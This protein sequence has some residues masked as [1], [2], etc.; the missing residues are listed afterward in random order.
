MGN[1]GSLGKLN[2]KGQVAP[3]GVPQTAANGPVLRGPGGPPGHAAAPVIG[4]RYPT[5]FYTTLLASF[6]MS[7]LLFFI[8]TPFLLS[9]YSMF[10]LETNNLDVTLASFE[11]SDHSTVQNRDV[12]M[13]AVKDWK[14]ALDAYDFQ[15][16][17]EQFGQS[18]DLGALTDDFDIKEPPIGSIP[19]KRLYIQYKVD[20]EQIFEI[21]D[22]NVKDNNPFASIKEAHNLLTK[23]DYIQFMH[24]LEDTLQELPF[25]GDVCFR[26]LDK[27]GN[28]KF[29]AQAYKEKLNK[30]GDDYKMGCV[31]F[32][33]FKQYYFPGGVEMEEYNDAGESRLFFT[34]DTTDDKLNSKIRDTMQRPASDVLTTF[35]QNPSWQWFGDALHTQ[36]S[37]QSL[38][39]RTQITIG[40]P[41][42]NIVSQEAAE[43][44]VDGYLSNFIKV[45]DTVVAVTKTAQGAEGLS[46]L[47]ITR[48][49]R[50][51]SISYGGDGLVESQLREA[52]ERDWWFVFAGVCVVLFVIGGYTHSFFIATMSVGQLA[53]TY[54]TAT[55]IHFY[56]RDEDMSLLTLLSFYIMLTMSTD[57]VMISFNTFRQ[58]AFMETSGRVNTLNIPQRMAFCFRKA[59]A[60][61]AMSHMSA[62]A[63]FIVNTVSS[64]PAIRD[65][66]IFMVWLV[67]VNLYMFLT[68]FP[69]VLLLH[70]FHISRKRRNA[71]RQKEI[72]LRKRTHF[73]P[74]S[75]RGALRQLD[76]VSKKANGV[77][78]AFLDN[79]PRQL[80]NAPVQ[81]AAPA[82]TEGNEG[83]EKEKDDE[84]KPQVSFGDAGSRFGFNKLQAKF[85]QKKRVPKTAEQIKAEHEALFE[86]FSSTGGLRPQKCRRKQAPNGILRIPIE[87]T[88][89]S[90]AVPRTVNRPAGGNPDSNTEA[91]SLEDY[92][93]RYRAIWEEE[94][95]IIEPSTFLGKGVFRDPVS[96][97]QLECAKRIPM[98]CQIIAECNQE[99]RVIKQ[100]YDDEEC[101]GVAV[102][103]P[104]AP[105]QPH[106]LV[107]NDGTAEVP[108]M[109]DGFEQ[110]GDVQS[111]HPHV[112]LSYTPQQQPPPSGCWEKFLNWCDQRRSVKR[113]FG[114]FGKR[115]GE[116]R[117]EKDRRILGK[118]AKREGYTSIERFF[119][120]RY[121]PLIALIYP[122]VIGIYLIKLIIFAAALLSHLEATEE[123]PQLLDFQNQ[124]YHY[125]AIREKFPVEGSCD[126]C[127]AWFRPYSDFPAPFGR[128]SDSGTKQL[129][130]V[131]DWEKCDYQMFAPLDR[132][133]I[134][135]GNNDCLDCMGQV[136]E[137]MGYNTSSSCPS[138][139][140]NWIPTAVRTGTTGHCVDKPWPCPGG[141]IKLGYSGWTQDD[142]GRCV[143]PG[144]AGQELNIK[145]DNGICQ[146]FVAPPENRCTDQVSICGPLYKTGVCSRC[147]LSGYIQQ[148]GGTELQDYYPAPV[149]NPGEPGFQPKCT[150]TCNKDTCVRGT[151]D[152]VTGE[153]LCFSDYIRGFY[154]HVV[155]Y[156]A[157]LGQS[158]DCAACLPGFQPDIGSSLYL[159]AG[160]S[161][162]IV[163]CTLECMQIVPT[164]NVSDEDC[165][166][167]C[168]F[169]TPTPE[170]NNINRGNKGRCMCAR[171][172]RYEYLNET[173]VIELPDV[174][175]PVS[176][177]T[178]DNVAVGYNCTSKRRDR[179]VN[180]ALDILT[181]ECICE[182]D[183][184]D[185]GSCEYQKSCS[186]HGRRDDS[187][188][189]RCYACWEGD[190]CE[191]SACKNSGYCTDMS[192]G[193][194]EQWKCV[195]NGVWEGPDCNNCP[196]A[197]GEHSRC[198]LEWPAALYNMPRSQINKKYL[199]C[200]VSDSSDCFGYWGGSKCDQCTPPSIIPQELHHN[201]T[202]D[203]QGR[204]YGCDGA[205]ATE[206]HFK[207]CAVRGFELG[208]G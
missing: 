62:A 10:T 101:D 126:Y 146:S 114:V 47:G 24:E 25:W 61:L 158:G 131:T 196:A 78:T 86:Q 193:P 100:P 207:V 104:E 54:F 105:Q 108:V 40:R 65:F 30:N 4:K 148:R 56:A 8:A 119:Y 132:C 134:C 191:R 12:T 195:C 84:N 122:F 68:V 52:K 182:D 184:N 202:C 58:S 31:P 38:V 192:S 36:D 139:S 33:S 107:N 7:C 96:Q 72:L 46:Q 34:F 129:S 163:P 151:C 160:S 11:I 45:M 166:C 44:L 186:Y 173:D 147:Y 42:E 14:R 49:P 103:A 117:E 22:C 32:T 93:D 188:L 125:E 75:V 205:E 176:P 183:F 74:L 143:L 90:R 97:H 18:I 112:V 95:K 1:V 190:S 135:G 9:C 120:N 85:L 157:M 50:G 179:C 87:F 154:T 204:I 180:G 113:R 171:C 161:E 102:P 69:C 170:F 110:P 136:S 118:R 71:Q 16:T 168:D 82:Q 124:I 26:S 128:G 150:V 153:C 92:R 27:A 66:G 63:A 115:V 43:Q 37:K 162:S 2:K 19:W 145:D 187:G 165:Q 201:I 41:L 76:T 53:L 89:F 175:R 77:P 70:H 35:Y 149:G 142:C 155:P 127:G 177:F 152:D 200:W 21:S 169:T 20:L 80:V 83:G 106:P 55:F 178:N 156:N 189:C 28:R 48:F 3:A 51:L 172:K 17:T 208:W 137:C 91:V 111:P 144:H 64:V 116:T 67:C 6:P 121:T 59:G 94:A 199:E 164:F 15:S 57:G 99:L 138:I 60:A 206:T 133:G 130:K 198:P 167:E 203:P 73:H 140:C 197:C 109:G 194:P 141:T 185:G 23:T 98:V 174:P 5:Y 79:G 88:S 181:G 159:I 29:S 81:Q 13:S 123:V 39:L